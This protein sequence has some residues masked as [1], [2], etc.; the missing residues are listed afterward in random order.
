[1][2]KADTQAPRQRLQGPLPFSRFQER[3]RAEERQGRGSMSPGLP[4]GARV[5]GFC[6]VRLPRPFHPWHVVV[7]REPQHRLPQLFYISKY[8]WPCLAFS[9]LRITSLSDPLAKDGKAW[10]MG[11]GG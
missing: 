6:E 1:M 9:V 11:K 4:S 2:I 10:R 7:G 8:T 3:V 5:T